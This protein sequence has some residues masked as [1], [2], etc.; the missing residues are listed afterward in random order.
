MPLQMPAIKQVPSPNYSPSLIAHD[1]VIL[2]LMEGGYEGSIAWL[3]K[4]STKAS[5]HLCMNEDG[6]EFTQLV[7]LSMKAWAQVAYNSKGVSIEAP[8]FTAKG[9]SDRT[10]GGMARATAWL[11]HAYGIPCQW[12]QGGQGRGF[13]CHHD[14]GASGGGHVDICGVGDAT[15]RKF[16]SFVEQEYDT[17]DEEP[18]PV[19]ALHGAPAPHQVEL[20][21]NVP[22]E[23]SHGGAS[24]EGPP[25]PWE[26]GHD[27][28]SLFP[29]G[30]AAD[31]QWRLNKAGAQP[32]L[33]VDGQAGKLTRNALAAFQGAH[34]LHIDGIIGPKTWAALEA[35]SA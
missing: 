26:D 8:G 34:R 22:P 17:F 1:L 16:M 12:A 15:W 32:P 21:P 14:L 4:T 10:L 35:A 11:L 25:D 24:R 29:R 28:A 30:S 6:S 7:P 31:I 20:A 9:V 5:A 13:C 3:C 19:W 23:P 33:D 27:T 18:I 2:H